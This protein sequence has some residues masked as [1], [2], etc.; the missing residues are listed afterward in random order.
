MN[1]RGFTLLELIVVMGILAI[2]V[3]MGVPKFLGYTKDANVTAM[4]ADIKILEQGAIQYALEN[5]DAWPVSD[6]V[7][8]NDISENTKLV[9]NEVLEHKGSTATVDNL[10]TANLL[11]DLDS[12]KMEPYIRSLHNDI[13][14]YLIVNRGTVDGYANQLEGYVFLKSAIADSKGNYRAS[15]TAI[16]VAGSEENSGGKKIRDPI[17]GEIVIATAEDLAKIGTDA[18]FPL[19]GDYILM[20]DI[21]LSGYDNWSPIGSYSNK[22]SGS[23]DGNGFVISGLTIDRSANYQGLF[24]SAGPE[25]KLLNITLENVDVTANEYVGGLVGYNYGEITNCSVSGSVTGSDGTGGLV[26]RNIGGTIEFS[27]ATGSV[28]GGNYTGGLVGYNSGTIQSSYWDK[29]A[30]G[31]SSS[32][33]GTGKT[34]VEMK[35][36]STF[37]GWDFSDTW[38]IDEGISYPYLQE[39]EQ[40]PHPQ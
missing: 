16:K 28:E 19:D 14:D 1:K 32:R 38:F 9:I 4:E 13:S 15:L 12:T 2:L 40:V 7:C 6:A 26:G 36:K 33:G 11:C 8:E 25:S 3:A 5:S 29:E 39:N 23:F 22:Y 30:S 17:E 24:A 20:A 27:Y 18:D 31:R 34:T 37:D 35:Q 10:L 21:D